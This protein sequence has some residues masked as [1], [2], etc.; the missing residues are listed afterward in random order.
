MSA[1]NLKALISE[2]LVKSTERIKADQNSLI[3]YEKLLKTPNLS[4]FQ[5]KQI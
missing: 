4:A 3:E 2:K 5:L 1:S